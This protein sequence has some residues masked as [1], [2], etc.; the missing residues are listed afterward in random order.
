MRCLA[1]ASLLS[2]TAAAVPDSA[3]RYMVTGFDRIRANGPFEIEVVPGTN[4]ASATGDAA[5][6]DRLSVRVQGNTLVVNSG[7]GA[8]APRTRGAARATKIRI[9]APML[10]GVSTNGGAQIHVTEMRAARVDLALDGAGSLDIAGIRADELYVAHNGMGLLKLAGN[11]INVRV[12]GSVAGTVDG[13]GFTAND[14]TLLWDSRGPLTMGVRYT[15]QI[16]ANG[17]GPV[18]I[19]G[20]PFCAI[21]GTAPVTCEGNVQRR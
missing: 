8:F 3:R 13:A 2:L 15:A 16:T 6:L 5:A 14:A 12:R 7:T 10:R 17:L 1:L 9:A 20:K 11:A 21:R 4:S 19:I 18:T